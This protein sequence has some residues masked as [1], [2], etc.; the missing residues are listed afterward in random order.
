MIPPNV[1]PY[2]IVRRLG[3]GGQGVVYLGEGRDGTRVAVKVLRSGGD[4]LARE[5]AAARRVEP[6]CIAQVLDASAGGTPYIVTEYVEGPSLA[7]AGRHTG[8]DLQRLAVATAT[9]L[10]AIHRA[11]VV[12]RDFK[13]G[14]VLLGPDGPRVI[15]FGIARSGTALTMTSSIVGTP[16]YMAPEQLAGVPVGPAADVFAWAGVMV[17][18][19]TGRPPFGDDSLPAVITRIQRAVPEFGNLPAPLRP[20]VTRCLEK[21]PAMRPSM[22]DVLFELIGGGHVP[23]AAPAPA[24]AGRAGRPAAPVSSRPPAR[25]GSGTQTP[26]GQTL[27]RQPSGGRM[28]VVGGAML[29]AVVAAGLVVVLVTQVSWPVGR[30]PVALPSTAGPGSSGSVPAEDG[31]TATP[32]TE[33]GPTTTRGRTSEP[34]ATRGRTP[35]P[36]A[37]RTRSREPAAARTPSSSRT[38][39]ASPSPAATPSKTADPAGRIGAVRLRSEGLLTGTCYRQSN[40]AAAVA[41]SRKTPF[42]YRW[43]LDGRDMGKAAAT[44]PVKLVLGYAHIRSDGPHTVRFKVL[45]PNAMTRSF[46]FSTCDGAPWPEE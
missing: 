21:D 36:S 16:A 46:S 38:P 22:Q 14:N 17:F 40:I 9:A 45:S 18:A 28:L 42:T 12:H 15:D 35:E 1:G 10:A 26:G 13:P 23:P 33:P 11:G 39:T 41:A 31:R 25:R 37:T 20:I 34:T 30:S 7:E 29:G 27:D 3:E 4:G 5:I 32:T 2:R 43:I 44:A 19:A 24:A 8:A 6:F